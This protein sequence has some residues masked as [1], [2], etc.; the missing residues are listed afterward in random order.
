MLSSS[1]CY[2][3]TC[4][5]AAFVLRCSM[6][7][8]KHIR[9]QDGLIA[10]I[11]QFIVSI[12]TLTGLEVLQSYFQVWGGYTSICIN[13]RIKRKKKEEQATFLVRFSNNRKWVSCGI[14][15]P[16]RDGI[17]IGFIYC[18]SERYQAK[19]NSQSSCKSAHICWFSYHPSPSF[20]GIKV[21][22]GKSTLQS[23]TTIIK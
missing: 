10:L 16:Y 14:K 6:G 5:F 20:L 23:N 21:R 8:T 9:N 15:E 12:F 1:F 4:C 17:R 7:W 13:T 19:K 22:W 3:P 18:I 2:K 11:F